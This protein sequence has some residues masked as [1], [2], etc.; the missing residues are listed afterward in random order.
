MAEIVYE[1]KVTFYLLVT[2]IIRV[3][4]SRKM[5]L[6]GHVARIREMRNVHEILA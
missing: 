1:R 5:K 3:M 6:V 2:N 4:K